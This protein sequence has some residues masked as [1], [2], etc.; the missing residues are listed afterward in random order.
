MSDLPELLSVALG[1]ALLSVGRVRL[2]PRSRPLPGEYA[3]NFW[4]RQPAGSPRPLS[5]H[6][7]GLSNV[8]GPRIIGAR[9]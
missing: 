5:L 3:Y 7:T 4:D 1:L 6:D 9:R 2:G 8:V